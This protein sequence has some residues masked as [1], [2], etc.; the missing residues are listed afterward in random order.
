MRW[1]RG[2]IRR[3]WLRLIW[4][5]SFF[6]SFVS[7]LFLFC[8]VSFLLWL[9]AV[10]GFG[11]CFL[12]SC[13]CVYVLVDG[14]VYEEGPGEGWG[15]LIHPHTYLFTILFTCICFT[16]Y[17]LNYFTYLLVFLCSCVA[18]SYWLSYFLIYLFIYLFTWIS[19]SA[20][21]CFGSAFLSCYGL[22]SWNCVWCMVYMDMDMDANTR[23][24]SIA[25]I[26]AYTY[27][28]FHSGG[29]TNRARAR[30]REWEWEWRI[31]YMNETYFYR[32]SEISHYPKNKSIRSSWIR[33]RGRRVSI[34]CLGRWVRRIH[35]VILNFRVSGVSGL[36][37]KGNIHLFNFG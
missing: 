7:F 21:I 29:G 31:G 2:S 17:S 16:I 35:V 32:K 8:F 30:L 26:H 9:F 23:T 36:A 33:W 10:L 20:L 13:S 15:S 3:L 27:S 14:F 25:R 5:V 1:S 22:F 37:L 34:S 4:C 18:C 28:D 11:S 19:S 24:L 12:F 6:F